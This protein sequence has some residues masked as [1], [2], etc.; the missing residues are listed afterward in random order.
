MPDKEYNSRT[1][2]SQTIRQLVV[3]AIV[4]VLLV[5]LAF[6]AS[7]LGMGALVVA[8]GTFAAIG[9]MIALAWLALQVIELVAGK[10]D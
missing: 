2:Q 10:D 9:V 1:Y 5:G 7:R 4:L 8:I 3:G 6:V